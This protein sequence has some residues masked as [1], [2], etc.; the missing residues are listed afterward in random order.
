MKSIFIVLSIV[1]VIIGSIYIFSFSS[2]VRQERFI[3]IIKKK[4][5][6][7][8]I[9]VVTISPFVLYTIITLI[10]VLLRGDSFPAYHISVDENQYIYYEDAYYV[11]ITDDEEKCNIAREYVQGNWI[12][13]GYVRW[14]KMQFP[15]IHYW[16]PGYFLEDL[17]VSDNNEYLY[18]H[19]WAGS[20][21]FH[22]IYQ[23]VE[24]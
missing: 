11:S 20:T 24:E 23:R 18:T 10:L 13:K 16:I 19:V 21:S 14:E 8:K 7:L 15:Y 5:T 9:F 17:T 12:E 3:E 2:S 22:E 4:K 6:W 1:C